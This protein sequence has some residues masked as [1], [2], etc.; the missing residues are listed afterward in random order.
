MREYDQSTP[1]VTPGASK[2][3]LEGA[4][5]TVTNS[6]TGFGLIKFIAGPQ[7]D[8]VIRVDK[9]ITTVG[10]DPDNDIVLTDQSVSPHHARILCEE[11]SWSVETINP[12]DTITVNKHDLQQSIIHDCTIV[13]IGA[14]TA[15]IFLI[16][17]ASQRLLDPATGNTQPI[18]SHSP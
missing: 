12:G 15:F 11:G 3:E 17:L 6:L 7:M 8:K 18:G 16:S 1:K 13:G 9:A 5:M 10:S 14:D 4:S 2:L